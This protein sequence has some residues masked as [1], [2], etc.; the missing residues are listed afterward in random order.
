MANRHP[1]RAGDLILMHDD[2]SLSLAWLRTMLPVWKADGFSFE[3]L[4][5]HA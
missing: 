5:F 3:A 1:S 2:D 4:P